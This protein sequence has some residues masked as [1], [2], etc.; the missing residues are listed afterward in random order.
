MY[1]FTTDIFSIYIYIFRIYKH[2]ASIHVYI[3]IYVYKHI[4]K[5]IYYITCIH[6]C[7]YTHN[8]IDFPIRLP[9]SCYIVAAFSLY[10]AMLYNVY[11][12]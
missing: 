6:I 1:I 11:E 2:S 5:C 12:S 7:I 9:P 4:Y 3:Y 8:L 10:F